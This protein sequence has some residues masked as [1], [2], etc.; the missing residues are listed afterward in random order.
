MSLQIKENKVKQGYYEIKQRDNSTMTEPMQHSSD[1]R[2]TQNFSDQNKIRIAKQANTSLSLNSIMK[3]THNQKYKNFS[4]KKKL[5]GIKYKHAIR[6]S[7]FARRLESKA[8]T[9]SK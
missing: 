2:Q 4:E 7:P 9:T 5:I 1:V 6:P 8:G 3:Q